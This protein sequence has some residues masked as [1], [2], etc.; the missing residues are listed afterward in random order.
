MVKAIRWD[1]AQLAEYQRRTQPNKT[2]P[3]P[4]KPPSRSKYGSQKVEDAAGVKHDSKK[5][6]RRWVVLQIL[7]DEGKITD[8]R[9]QVPFELA[10]KVKLEGEA[11]TKPAL[12]YWADFVYMQDG[13]LVVE[14]VKSVST[15]KKEAYR[16]KRHLVATVLGIHIKEV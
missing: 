6:A 10:P 3:A 8:L 12:R 9:R 16:I 4:V 13:V 2:A 1:A 11:R 14:D 7:Q 5:E 15:R